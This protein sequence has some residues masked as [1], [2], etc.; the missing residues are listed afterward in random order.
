L[1]NVIVEPL[2]VSNGNSAVRGT[3]FNATALGHSLL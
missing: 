1:A 2:G 3:Q